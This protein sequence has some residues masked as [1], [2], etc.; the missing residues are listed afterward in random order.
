MRRVP[1][2]RM[3][4][5]AAA[6][7]LPLALD[8]ASGSRGEPAL[9]AVQLLAIN[10]F[11]GNL[12]PPSG[13]NGQM[14]STPA[15]GAEY[16]A[17]HLASAIADNP[18]SI[19]VAAGDLIGASPLISSLFH[20]EPTI[21][22]M[23]AM[24]LAVS[25]VGNHE[26]DKGVGELLRMKRGGC[27]P[28]DG[29]QGG[30]EF[31]GA[32]FQYLSANVVRQA[33][34]ATLFPATAVRTVGGVRVGF[35]GETL[36][37]TPRIVS[38]AAIRGLTFLDEAIV[39]NESAA[40]LERQGVHAI[41]LLVHEGG[42]QRPAEGDSDPNECVNFGGAIESVV[43]KLTANIPV[44]ISGHTHT[45]YNCRIGD[46]LVTS[47]GAY[48]QMI[49][50]INLEI[51]RS[52]GR[53]A[54]AS[55][56]NE[57]VTRDVAR[58]PA[59]TS[60]IEKYGALAEGTANRVV[61]AVVGDIRRSANA[62]GESPLG[63]IIADA[64][65]AA[66][67]AAANGAAVVAFTNE[68]G[69]RSDIVAGAGPLPARD[70]R[71]AEVTYG[72]LFRVQPFGN[73]LTV[74]TMTGDMIKRL[75]E[76]QFDNPR[77]G[78]AS[79]L[80]VSSGFTYRYRLKAPAGQ[81]VERNSIAIAGRRIGPADRVRV[82]AVNFLVDGGGGYPALGQGTGKIVGVPDIDALV[83]YFKGHSPVAPGRQDRIIR[84]N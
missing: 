3:L 29:C 68:G 14:N 8:G 7:A 20:D 64:Q 73:V 80:Q 22:A 84:I 1:L 57:I 74:F 33:T 21:E 13:A 53:I 38:A 2:L 63:D 32:A 59:V 39:A 41:V 48:G 10:D 79:V 83:A 5:L 35:I 51:D 30:G 54:R 82:A 65:L 69:I 31:K 42:R 76:Q 16:L 55:A 45:F 70:G 6:L 18:N 58:D 34:H 17:T 40:R 47:A 60:I 62:A 67:S 61:G 24:N 77:P 75:L 50:R 56:A 37:G 81:H 43:G 27:H 12:E 11:H 46:H 4:V 52:T 71:V 19:V 78:A 15:G 25:S 36:K 28:A 9:V 49:T 23:N 44:V 26:F 66:T 72:D